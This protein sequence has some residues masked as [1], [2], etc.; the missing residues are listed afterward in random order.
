MRKNNLILEF[1]EFNAQRLNPDSAQMGVSAVDNPQLSINAFDKHQD[2]IR[3]GISK[4]NDIM[5]SVAGS[6]QF[7]SLKAKLALED[8]KLSSL[9]VLRII[10]AD[11]VNY[12]FYISFVIGEK[13][14]NGVIKKMN[15]RNP[16]FQSEVFKDFDSLVQTR[17][18]II[19]TKGL[20]IKLL[21][22]W[23]RP[24]EGVYELLNNQIYCNS[25]DLGK[26]VE[27]NKGEQI[28]VV[29]TF[30]NKIIVKYKNDYYNLSNDNFIYFNYWFE[31]ID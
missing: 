12:D 29:T 8:Q 13:E 11:S 6:S 23:L 5:Y 20:I 14:Y 9:K 24:V 15:S 19:R 10:S 26:R 27:I 30:E 16:E 7:K 1:S 22:E 18:W 2:A 28:E 31:K 4:I 25:V 3:A 17:E 21:K